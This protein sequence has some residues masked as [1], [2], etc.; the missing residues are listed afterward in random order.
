MEETVRA[1]YQ[2]VS[3][4][5]Q[6]VLCDDGLLKHRIICQHLCLL[7]I[8]GAAHTTQAQDVLLGT[9]DERANMN[10]ILQNDR[11]RQ[12]DQ[13]FSQENVSCLFLFSPSKTRN[14]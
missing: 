7:H 1:S 11:S 5:D 13:V 12:P 10:V 4:D 8:C 14:A 3:A 2:A 6:G 9:P